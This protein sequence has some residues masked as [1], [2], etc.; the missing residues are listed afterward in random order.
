[1]DGCRSPT[2]PIAAAGDRRERPLLDAMSTTIRRP[3]KPM[4]PDLETTP[5]RVPLRVARAFDRNVDRSVVT[6]VMAVTIVHP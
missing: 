5:G 4:R 6:L 2:A 1:V 3:Q